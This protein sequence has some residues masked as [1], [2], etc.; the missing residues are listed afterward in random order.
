MGHIAHSGKLG[1][2]TLPLE[3]FRDPRLNGTD[4]KFLVALFEY[5]DEKTGK[6]N[7]G[8]ASIEAITG[9][10]KSNLGRTITRLVGFGWLKYTKGNHEAANDYSIM[11]PLESGFE[12]R[13]RKERLSDEEWAVEKQKRKEAIKPYTVKKIRDRGQFYCMGAEELIEE[14]R[15]EE[16][17]GYHYIPDDVL[18]NFEI[19]RGGD[20]SKTA[21]E[22]RR[23][24]GV[25]G[26]RDMFDVEALED[27][28]QAQLLRDLAEM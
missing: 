14:L 26:V 11:I 13:V 2:I 10:P 7:V 1:G 12:Y 24:E 28:N 4:I 16:A 17:A 27:A 25:Q 3:V 22:Q 8:G 21:R 15:N 9:M 20:N 5:R 18:K 23:D 6:V 19:V